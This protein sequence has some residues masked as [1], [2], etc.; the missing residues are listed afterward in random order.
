MLLEQFHTISGFVREG[1]AAGPGGAAFYAAILLLAAPV[2]LFYFF[3]RSAKSRHAAAGGFQLPRLRKEISNILFELLF[4]GMALL[5]LTDNIAYRISRNWPTRDATVHDS[6]YVCSLSNYSSDCAVY[7]VYNY[8][9]STVTAEIRDSSLVIG[10]ARAQELKAR[11]PIG[12]LVK[13]H[14]DPA[15]PWRSRLDGSGAIGWRWAFLCLVA[16]LLLRFFQRHP[17]GNDGQDDDKPQKR[18]R[19]PGGV[20]SADPP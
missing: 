9:T 20:G 12:S 10:R 11:Y 18:P 7:V 8:G 1:L 13:V 3:A 15:R 14:Y 2:L 6:Y 16:F 5:V 17:A 19:K 4:I